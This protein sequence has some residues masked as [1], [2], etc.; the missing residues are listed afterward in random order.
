MM[1]SKTTLP[2]PP[3]P[4]ALSLSRPD[5]ARSSPP[6]APRRPANGPSVSGISPQSSSIPFPSPTTMTLQLLLPPLA[7]WMTWVRQSVTSVMNSCALLQTPRLSNLPSPVLS[8]TSSCTS[9]PQKEEKNLP[10]NSSS[11]ARV[12]LLAASPP[13]MNARWC[14]C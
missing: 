3:A 7:S 8:L 10:I 5:G 1:S 11:Y 4:Y 9:T 13:I 12:V 2:S 6:L 14:M